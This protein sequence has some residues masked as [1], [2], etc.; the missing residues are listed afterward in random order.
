MERRLGWAALDTTALPAWRL[1]LGIRFSRLEYI[2]SLCVP[3]VRSSVILVFHFPIISLVSSNTSRI[4]SS[5][6]VQDNE[7]D[8]IQMTDSDRQE[9]L[10][11]DIKDILEEL[12]D[13]CVDNPEIRCRR[14]SA[15][16]TMPGL[17]TM[18]FK[19]DD[20]SVPRVPDD[21]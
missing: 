17:Y 3:C 14:I 16:I 19:P 15:N 11:I 2:T 20:V 1:H 6:A 8:D 5:V 12:Q 13:S 9:Q 7:M 21:L 4:K 10:G 18:Y